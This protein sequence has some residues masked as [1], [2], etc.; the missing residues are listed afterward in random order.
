MLGIMGAPSAL[1]HLLTRVPKPP[2]PVLRGMTALIQVGQMTNTW[3][4]GCQGAS[5]HQVPFD[6]ILSP[7]QPQLPL[8]PSAPLDHPSLRLVHACHSYDLQQL[9]PAPSCPQPRGCFSSFLCSAPRSTLLKTPPCLLCPHLRS[10]IPPRIFQS[11]QFCSSPLT[12]P[13]RTNGNFLLHF[14]RNSLSAATNVQS[15]AGDTSVKS[16]GPQTDTHDVT[17]ELTHHRK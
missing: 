14:P 7:P 16:T 11:L 15:S 9:T 12:R 3:P 8:P 5:P 13:C 1:I 10:V 2:A 17:S 6:D 4:L